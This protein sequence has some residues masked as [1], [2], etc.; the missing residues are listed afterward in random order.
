M[1]AIAKM[2]VEMERGRELILRKR[3]EEAD[4]YF[5]ALIAQRPGDPE[6]IRGCVQVAQARKDFAAAVDRL[7]RLLELQ[8]DLLHERIIR[9][10]LR[11]MSGALEPLKAEIDSYLDM[12]ERQPL[13]IAAGQRLLRVLQYAATGSRRTLQLLRLRSLIEEQTKV[14]TGHIVGYRV[15]LAEILFAL[16]DY[17]EFTQMVTDLRQRAPNHQKI[18]PLVRIAEKYASPEF[19]DFTAPKVFGIGLSRTATSSLNEALEA[20]GFHAIHWLNPHS[21]NLIAQEDFFLFDAFTDI[22]VS[23]QFERLYHCF[24]NA[25]FV[26]TT[27]S[28]ESW[29]KSIT[30]HYRTHRG[31][32]RPSQLLSPSHTQRFNFAAGPIVVNLYGRYPTW[33]EAFEAYDERVRSFF[34]D[35]PAASLLELNICD[36]EGWEKLCAFLDRPVPS[37]P[38]PNKNQSAR[39]SEE[40]GSS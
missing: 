20:L 19:P 25:R 39:Y 10:H 17:G 29:E 38:F 30:L 35:K 15:L 23:H 21:R 34:R 16:G 3:F 8:P 9:G 36:G 28:V 14:R 26:Y 33:R 40:A 22:P 5:E 2:T 1:E 6:P 4:R 24:P 13:T 37:V 12:A 32:D 18:L 27:R 7:D 31:I 11:A